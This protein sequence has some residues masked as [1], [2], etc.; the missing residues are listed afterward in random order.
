VN[1]EYRQEEYVTTANSQH[2]LPGRLSQAWRG[3]RHWRRTRPFWG[4]LLTALA[5]V[6]IFFTTQ[7]SLS[8][9]TFQMGPTGF[10]SW[11]IPTIL[12]ACGM[13]LW[14]SPQQRMFYSIVAAVT[15][16][17]SLIGVNLGGFFIGMLLGMVGSALGFAWVPKRLPATAPAEPADTDAPADADGSA[18]AD[19]PVD[20]E[21]R[22][23]AD[24][25]DD[26]TEV[27]PAVGTDGRPVAAAP[28]RDPKLLAVT[29]VLLTV[30]AA[31]GLALRDQS[32][33]QAAPANPCPTPSPTRTATP[34]PSASRPAD[35]SPSPSSSPSPSASPEKPRNIITDIIDGIGDLFRPGDDD[36][37]SAAPTPSPAPQEAEPSAKPTPSASAKPGKPDQDDDGCATPKPTE[38]GDVEP[39]EPL[40]K[41]AAEPGQPKV[42][43]EPGKLTGSKVTMT[44]LR[45]DGI[46]DLPT[47]GGTLKTLKF[48][49]K[50]AVTE[51]FLLQVKGPGAK[52]TRYATDE[53]TVER[54]KGSDR[55]V[56]FYCTRFTGKLLG[57]K[58]T[59]E[60]N[61]PFPDGIPVTFPVP[62]SFTDPEM[63]LAFVDSDILTA[64][65]A[66]KLDMA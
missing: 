63:Q 43:A 2:A 34:S 10:L 52:S 48:S 36:E 8:G 3:F 6:E 46:V 14:F 49:M 4:G 19:G 62:V 40:P 64:K 13:L 16:V 39:G 37:A 33:V 61:L 12:V 30:S 57:I 9:L 23:D 66:L 50:K 56:A 25:L 54:A 59:L 60:P 15:A 18:D 58:L 7:M 53:L 28:Y 44:G 31:G 29:L 41:I 32:P 21:G 51:D 42:A 35:D 47:D 17:F 5:G 22:A 11:L 55:D 65:P 24:R 38:P 20:A 45:F 1:R 26:S 27:L